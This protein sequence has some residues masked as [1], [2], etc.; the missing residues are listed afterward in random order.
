[1]VIAKSQ[2]ASE[3]DTCTHVGGLTGNSD[4]R[5]HTPHIRLRRELKPGLAPGGFAGQMRWWVKE[6]R[7]HGKKERRNEGEVVP[8]G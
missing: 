5:E 8:E 6:R 4:E 1:M 7:L 2:Q 3:E